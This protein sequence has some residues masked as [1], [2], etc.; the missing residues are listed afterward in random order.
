VRNWAILKRCRGE[1]RK[2]GGSCFNVGFENEKRAKE[3]KG[4]KKKK[5]EKENRR[6]GR[7][8]AY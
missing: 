7:P 4:K 8:L 2:E 1:G 5:K 3:K 6:P